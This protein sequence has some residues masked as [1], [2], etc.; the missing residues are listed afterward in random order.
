MS[1]RAEV[2]AFVD[3]LVPEGWRGIG[4][5]DDAAHAAFRVRARAALAERGWVAPAWPVAYGGAGLGAAELVVLVEELTGAGV[6]FGSEPVTPTSTR[7]S[8]TT[9]APR[10]AWSSAISTGA[11]RWR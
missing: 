10:R 3:D 6:P 8:S 11:G 4:A 9:P 2:R 5:L 1:F 7:C